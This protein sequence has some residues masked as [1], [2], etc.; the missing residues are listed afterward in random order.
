[1]YDMCKYKDLESSAEYDLLMVEYSL[2]PKTFFSP[3]WDR[4][5][6]VLELTM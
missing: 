4:A 3:F 5:L 6:A 1:M 2:L